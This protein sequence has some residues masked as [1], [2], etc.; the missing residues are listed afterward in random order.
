VHPSNNLDV[1]IGQGTIALELLD[2]IEGGFDAL[3]CPI[4]GGGLIAGMSIVYK[5]LNPKIKIIGAEPNGANDAYQSMKSG[6]F[7]PS[8]NANS[9]A[10]GLLSSMAILAWPIIRQNVDTIITVSD[11]EIKL[12]MKF[13][14]Q[15]MKIVIE[16]S[17]AVAVAVAM[18]KEFQEQ[19]KDIK[20]VCIVL[21][22]GNV[23]FEKFVW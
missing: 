4:S 10:D 13:V 3:I 8:K 18:S 2:Q 11:D 20:R 6:N 16:P 19:F 15:R 22:G 12:A 14:W 9:I 21:S 1:I 5:S 7:I 17:A 23:D